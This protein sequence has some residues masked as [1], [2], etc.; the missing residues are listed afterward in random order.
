MYLIDLKTTV[1]SDVAPW[2]LGDRP[3]DGGSKNL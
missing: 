3:E 1:F 2:V